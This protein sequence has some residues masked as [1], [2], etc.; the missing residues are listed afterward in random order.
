LPDLPREGRG[1]GVV[2]ETRCGVV[3]ER[4]GRG[5][6]PVYGAAGAL[7]Q[8]AIRCPQNAAIG[9]LNLFGIALGG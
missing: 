3:S 5:M 8:P 4:G 7:S 2:S 6:D 9:C 1:F